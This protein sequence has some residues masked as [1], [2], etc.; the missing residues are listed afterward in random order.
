MA[1]R[2]IQ[3]VFGGGN[4]GIMG[5]LADTVMENGGASVGV[6]PHFL[7]ER[8]VSHQG[9]TQLIL[10]ETMHQR[11]QTM[12]DMADAIVALPGGYGTL[13]EVF[14]MLTWR[15][16]EL[17]EKPIAVLNTAGFYGP[18][19]AQLDHMVATGFI[20]PANRAKLL[21]A[22]TPEELLTLLFA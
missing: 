13:E 22:D 15:Q 3:L 5:L 14:E 9:L 11:K 6:Q 10:V 21:V 4:I 8:E 12:H 19:I 2:G 20:S 1:T 18:M 17:H 16:L 7:N